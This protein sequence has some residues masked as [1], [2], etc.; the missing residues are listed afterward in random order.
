MTASPVIGIIKEKVYFFK[1]RKIKKKVISGNTDFIS[2][3]FFFYA[4]V[5]LYSF[6]RQFL[7]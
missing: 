6:W 3:K 1:K 2:C 4:T 5:S 7:G